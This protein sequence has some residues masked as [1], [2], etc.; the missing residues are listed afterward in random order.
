MWHVNLKQYLDCLASL[1]VCFL[2]ALFRSILLA[3]TQVVTLRSH[4]RPEQVPYGKRQR[5][6]NR[7]ADSFRRGTGWFGDLIV[8]VF[9][10]GC[11]YTV[12]YLDWVTGF[13]SV[14]VD[15]GPRK[16]AEVLV[17]SV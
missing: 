1:Q 14:W 9:I 8:I 16:V 12:V 6:L 11:R 5:M 4:T 3:E 17:F 15:H 10:L 13:C 7:P 2:H